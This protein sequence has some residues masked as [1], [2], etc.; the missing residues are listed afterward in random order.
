MKAH[1]NASFALKGSP[2]LLIQS[3]TLPSVSTV[4]TERRLRKHALDPI[5]T[6]TV[7]AVMSIAMALSKNALLVIRG[8]YIPI[9]KQRFLHVSL[10]AQQ[11]IMARL[12]LAHA[13]INR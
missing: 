9:I 11:G 1:M 13:D 4:M 8:F 12:F 2:Q 5:T 10:S 7:R 3:Q 6:R